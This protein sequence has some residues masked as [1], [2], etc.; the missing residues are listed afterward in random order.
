MKK[1]LKYFAKSYITRYYDMSKLVNYPQN[2]TTFLNVTPVNNQITLNYVENNIR[3]TM[4]FDSTLKGD[5]FYYC[6]VCKENFTIS[7]NNILKRTIALSLDS[8]DECVFSKTPATKLNL[9]NET[10][11]KNTIVKF[12]VGDVIYIGIDNY[13]SRASAHTAT[14]IGTTGGLYLGLRGIDSYFTRYIHVTN[15]A[16]TDIEKLLF[17]DWKLRFGNS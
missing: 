16:S 1:I 3:K 14:N 12:L 6:Y 7:V 4:I 5:S 8:K 9:F 17:A 15:Q 11:D 2:K 10:D 13:N